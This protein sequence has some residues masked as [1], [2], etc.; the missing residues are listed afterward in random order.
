[1]SYLTDPNKQFSLRN[2]SPNVGGFVNVFHAGTDDPAT[3]YSD[4]NGTRNARNILLDNNGRAIIIADATKAYRVEVRDPNGGLLWTVEP[5]YCIGGEG[6]GTPVAVDVPLVRVKF[7]NGSWSKISG[8]DGFIKPNPWGVD[9]LF[10]PESC[11]WHIDATLAVR[12]NT[13]ID[14]MQSLLLEWDWNFFI[15]E[16]VPWGTYSANGFPSMVHGV[17]YTNPETNNRCFG[18]VVKKDSR[19]DN[20]LSVGLN[21]YDDRLPESVEWAVWLDIFKVRDA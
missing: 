21:A 6:G 7:Q 1:M 5:A 11:W 8:D 17:D 14:L 16:G 4:F 2:G 15:A 9:S 20:W 13:A 12:H 10:L 3:T 18:F 19:T